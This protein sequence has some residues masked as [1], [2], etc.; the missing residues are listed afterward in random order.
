M[1]NDFSG[2]SR[3]VAL[4][5]FESGALTADSK[6]SNTLTAVN[7]PTVDGVTYQEGVGSLNLLNA[8]SQYLYIQDS[9]L[10]SGFPLKNGSGNLVGAVCCWIY[11]NSNGSYRRVWSKFDYVGSKRTFDVEIN[12]GSLNINWGNGESTF[13]TYST[14]ISI[15]TGRWYHLAVSFDGQNKTLYVRVYDSVAQTVTTYSTNPASLLGLSTADF[16]I[17]TSGTYPGSIDGS[18]WDGLIDELV[19]FNTLLSDAE[20]DAIR[21]ATFPPPPL[22]KIF[23]VLAQVEYTVPPPGTYI[24]AITGPIEIGAATSTAPVYVDAPETDISFGAATTS[25]YQGPDEFISDAEAEV[26]IASATETLNV[27]HSVAGTDIVITPVTE[28]QNYVFITEVGCGISIEPATITRVPV[29]GFDNNTGY[30]LID[31]SWLS[32]DPPFF[33]IV[34]NLELQLDPAAQEIIPYGEDYLVGSGGF[35]LGGEGEVS[36]TRPEATAIF[37]TGGFALGGTGVITVTTPETQ[38]IIG[39]GGFVLGGKG[40]I[41]FTKPAD[42]ATKHVTIIGSGGFQFGGA[43]VLTASKPQTKYIVG[44]GGFLLGYG[45]RRDAVTV[46]QPGDEDDAGKETIIAGKPVEFAL[47]GEGLLETSKPPVHTIDVGVVTFKLSG[48]G[49]LIF[50]RPPVTLILGEGGFVLTGG[51]PATISDTWSLSGQNYEPSYFT[52]FDFNSFATFRGKVYGAKDDG[53]YLLEGPDDNGEPI[54]SGVRIGP[55]NY[56]TDKQKRLRAIRLGGNSNGARVRVATGGGDEGQFD[57]DRGRI[58]VSRDLQDREFTLD[59]SDFEQLS[60]LEIVP[61]V[62]FRR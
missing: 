58:T 54:H 53:I 1:A 48:A 39:T 10:S 42:Q 43:G 24:T 23:Q 17:G 41:S 30:G 47:G 40:I 15:T 21:N 32:E 16:M 27:P 34:S 57:S 38:N 22:V 8:S 61:L 62:L 3:C 44:S 36:V 9:S 7:A 55:H 51:D 37:A 13:T 18:Y 5:R 28:T 49:G 45:F 20:I 31:I 19:V 4:W 6:G 59:I 11:A 52:G 14:G 33:A 60:Q 26:N 29:P 46:T 25:Y 56:G 12:D 35:A 50:R 2:D